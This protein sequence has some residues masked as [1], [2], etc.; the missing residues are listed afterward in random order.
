MTTTPAKV[1]VADILADK[2][3]LALENGTIPWQ[4]PWKS[5]SVQN[6]VSRK[7]YSGVNAFILGFFGSDNYYL[8]FNQIKAMGGT[9]EKG[10]KSMPVQFFSKIDA[11]KSK[12]KKEFLLRRYYNVFPM[13]K[14]TLADGKV[15][16]RM[17]KVISFTPV[18]EAERLANLSTTPV[19][20]GGSAAYFKPSS[21]QIGMPSKDS[22]KSVAHYYATLFHEIGHSLKAKGTHSVGF[23][24]EPYAKE[25]LVAELFS[26][27]CLA[28]C[29]LE[30]PEVT[31]NSTAYVQNWLTALKGDKTL[32][33][34]AASEAFKRFTALT[35]VEE[36]AEVSEE[37]EA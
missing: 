11:A 34:S 36:Q 37:V 31:T 16:K 33:L 6:A 19:T 22:F 9:L 24:S 25:E 29:G 27:L 1:T 26:S 10:T 28:E 4:K 7:A 3:I 30:A 12:D 32:I 15:F 21:H 13:N 5:V 14:V 8:T 20:H 18:A 23:G 17:D 2:F 35:K